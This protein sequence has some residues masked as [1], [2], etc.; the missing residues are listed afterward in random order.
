MQHLPR[1]R[2]WLL[3]VSDGNQAECTYTEVNKE[4]L[5]T[6]ISLCLMKTV[7]I[8]HMSTPANYKMEHYIKIT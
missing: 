7:I 3:A 6:K 2:K 5:G 4:I 8:Q 1:H